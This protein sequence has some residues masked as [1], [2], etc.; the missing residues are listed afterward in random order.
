MKAYKLLRKRKNG[1]LGPLFIN[2]KQVVEIGKWLKAEFHPTTHFAPRKGWHTTAKPE[3][4]HLHKRDR[5][6]A[7]VEIKNFEK[8]K[9][10][11]SQGGLW[12]IAQQM[13]LTGRIW[14]ES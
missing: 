12:Y 11:M 1:T 2:R 13:R 8:F 4:P 9:R 6:W 5:V 3:A 10:P 14:Q 7:E